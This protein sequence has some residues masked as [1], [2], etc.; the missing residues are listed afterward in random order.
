MLFLGF[1][2]GPRPVNNADKSRVPAH[3]DS[4]DNTQKCHS[5][6][7]KKGKIQINRGQP[8]SHIR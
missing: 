4:S 8:K 3:F 7:M 6:K 2:T 5:I 1:W